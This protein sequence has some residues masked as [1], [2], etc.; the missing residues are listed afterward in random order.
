M[1]AGPGMKRWLALIFEQVINSSIVAGIA[2]LSMM[3]G[4]DKVNGPAVGY[5]FGLTFLV[6]LRKYRDLFKPPAP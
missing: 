5:A 3:A 1:P 6:E 4:S 2:A